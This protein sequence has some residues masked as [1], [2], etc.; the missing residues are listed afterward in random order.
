MNKRGSRTAPK[1]H[2][3]VTVVKGKDFKLISGSAVGD[4]EREERKCDGGIE[5]LSLTTCTPSICHFPGVTDS[6][7]FTSTLTAH[8]CILGRPESRVR[9]SLS[10][11]GAALPGF[12]VSHNNSSVPQNRSRLVQL[13]WFA[14]SVA[15]ATQVCSGFVTTQFVEQCGDGYP[16]QSRI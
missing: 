9:V 13:F 2:V 10:D 16:G 7:L 15:V 12:R 11:T 1:I 6:R 8:A 3:I 14:P 4:G 5:D